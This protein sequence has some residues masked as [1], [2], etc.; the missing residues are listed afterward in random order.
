[1]PAQRRSSRSR[2]GFGRLIALVTAI[3]ATVGVTVP[4]LASAPHP[5]GPPARIEVLSTR[6]DLVSGSKALVAVDPPAGASA[7]AVRVHLDGRDITGAFA[8][9]A[10]GRFEGML[11]GLVPGRSM[12]TASVAGARDATL[13]II[14]HPIGGPVFAGPQVLPWVCQAGALDAQCNAPTIYSFMYMPTGANG[15]GYSASGVASVG[16]F[17]KYDPANPPPD[18][19]IAHT[20]TD[21]GISVPYII[22]VET[23]YLDRD[24]Y[25][26][27]VLF[28]PSKPWTPWAPQKQWNHKLVITH[29]ASCG[30]DHT[31]G[32]SPSVTDHASLSRGFAV[33]STAADNAG[34]NCNIVTQAESLVMAKEHLIDT[35]GEIRYTIGTGCSGGSLTQQQVANAYPGIYQGILPQCSF[36]DAWTTGQQLEDYVLLRR[37][38]EDP[39]KWG[40]APAW[41][42]TQIA[43][44]E[45]HPDHA[46]AVELST[47][48]G[49]LPD[50]TSACAGVPASQ[51]WSDSNPGGVRCSLQD[52]M[53]NVFGR[54]PQDGYAG[55]AYDNV[56]AQYGLNALMAGQI[57]PSQFVALN[58][59]VGSHDINYHW[60]PGRVAA[61]QGALINAYRSGAFNETN[62]LSQVAI[63][64]LRGP[65]PG[66]F[67]DA[68]RAFAVRARL[69]HANGT[70]AN[71]VIWEGFAPIVG[72]VTYT[73]QALV[74]MDS[75]LAAVER[76]HRNVSLPEKIIADK[77]GDVHDQCSDGVGQ[78]VRNDQACQLVVQLYSTPRVVAGESIATDVSKCQLKPLV[79]SDYL[80]V[81]FTANEWSQL[82]SDFPTGVCDYTKPG[83]YQQPTV[84][85]QTYQDGPGTGHPMSPIG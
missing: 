55:R 84:P 67:H 78:A 6:P 85:W 17:E 56:G 42:T 25:Q 18:G 50:P 31:T 19:L 47:L 76:D 53:V 11:T 59:A 15:A 75:W 69:D 39:T 46:N 14:D 26:I 79:R 74:A 66:A 43:A 36:P 29:G 24:Q 49:P 72:D 10:N 30:D 65:D 51:R 57:L 48:Y 41:T 4:A 7:Q 16:A 81:E 8:V 13:P 68:F 71:Q 21:Q 80:P 28:D 35:Y 9:R 45:G 23:G 32:T 63:I 61:D 82:Q 70:H 34:H 62:N 20:T 33:M 38:F 64:D 44:V 27:A 1:M 54:R 73:T 3:A 40:S 83:V 37:Y 77:P 22:R 60:Q 5:D 58:T 12:L 2:P 52:Y